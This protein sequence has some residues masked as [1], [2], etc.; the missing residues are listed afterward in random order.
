MSS[1]ADGRPTVRS[2]LCL[3]NRAVP[4][5]VEAA[6]ALEKDLRAAGFTVLEGGGGSSAAADLIVVLGGDGFLMESLR[7]LGYPTTPIFGANFG[8]VGFLMNR[9]AILED[10]PAMVRRWDFRS[11]DHAL[12]EGDVRV[13]GG[14]VIQR[15][16]LNDIV[17]ERMTR[18]SLRL[19]VYLDGAFFNRYGGD[20]FVLA[21]AAGST[22]YN[23]A[24]GGPVVHPSLDV[25]VVTPLYPHRASPFHSVQ[26]PLVLPAGIAIRI[27]AV[28]LPKRGMRIVSDGEPAEH[29]EQVDVRVSRRQI[30]L[31]RPVDHVFSET[32][33]RKFIGE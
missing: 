6:G 9:K 31:L 22:A 23:L 1:G 11:E 29:A 17:V 7:A 19:D 25:V 27:V 24:A 30:R 14:S 10:L 13:E 20:G 5:C 33:A 12:L 8:S 4:A 3:A 32:L 18:Q 16:A 21:T 28:D 26:F 2:I 15:V